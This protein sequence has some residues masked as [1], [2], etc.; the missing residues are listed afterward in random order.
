MGLRRVAGVGRPV[1]ATGTGVCADAT[2]ARGRT[3]ATGGGDP[4]V[5][6]MRREEGR[7]LGTMMRLLRG[8]GG[9]TS[10]ASGGGRESSFMTGS[11]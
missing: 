3:V 9:G 1:E 6:W 4:A 8:S 11:V 7:C 10:F 2:T 5:R